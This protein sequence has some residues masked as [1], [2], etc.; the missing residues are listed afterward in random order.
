MKIDIGTS[1]CS[2]AV[3]GPARAFGLVKVN[4]ILNV[5][6][7][8]HRTPEAHILVSEVLRISRFSV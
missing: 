5:C 1:A 2:V 4:E 7:F 3:I 6:I 8:R